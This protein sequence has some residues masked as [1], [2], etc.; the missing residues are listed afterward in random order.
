MSKAGESSSRICPQCKR[1][2]EPTWIAC[3]YCGTGLPSKTGRRP[4]R[5]CPQCK[6]LIDAG[7]LKCP[8]CGWNLAVAHAVSQTS[9]YT[10][11]EYVTDLWYLVPFLFGIIGGLVGYVGVRDRDQ[12]KADKLLGFGIAWNIIVAFIG[13]VWFFAR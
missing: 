2:L 6:S 8:H 13:Y 7:W 4:P 3:P 10:V 1:L 12:D 9:D 11:E 5:V